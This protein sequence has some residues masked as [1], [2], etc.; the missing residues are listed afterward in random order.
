MLRSTNYNPVENLKKESVEN[1][2]DDDEFDNCDLDD[3]DIEENPDGLDKFKTHDM[4][5]Y[6]N[7]NMSVR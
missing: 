3:D 5:T 6:P 7:Q 2:S 4:Q 1:N